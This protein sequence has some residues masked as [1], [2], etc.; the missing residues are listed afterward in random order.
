MWLN[1]P[2]LN[3]FP[4]IVF[5]HM[6]VKLHK[7]FF[8]DLWGWDGTFKYFF[9]KLKFMMDFRSLSYVI[10]DSINISPYNDNFM[11]YNR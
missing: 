2:G 11:S 4:C 7:V 5:P 10:I 9:S 8:V 3:S 1:R 6:K